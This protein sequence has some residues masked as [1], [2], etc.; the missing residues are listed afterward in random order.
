M[1]YRFNEAINSLEIEKALNMRLKS[2]KK[3]AFEKLA[4]SMAWKARLKYSLVRNIGW[5][6]QSIKAGETEM[7]RAELEQTISWLDKYGT[8]MKIPLWQEIYRRR[9]N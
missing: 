2:G 6:D 5:D 1:L 4:S 8:G 7:L 3:V 9:K